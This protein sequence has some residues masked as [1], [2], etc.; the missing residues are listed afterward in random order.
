[1]GRRGE[2]G[3]Q[4]N[5]NTG[6]GE[7]EWVYRER[8]ESKERITKEGARVDGYGRQEQKT[9]EQ[10]E[11]ARASRYEGKDCKI[12]KGESGMRGKIGR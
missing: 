3:R 11:A 1:M 6:M 10:T 5:Y 2:Y 4:G 12:R 8:M 9:R 7:G